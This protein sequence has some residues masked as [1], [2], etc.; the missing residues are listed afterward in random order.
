[1]VEKLIEWFQTEP[2][3]M[4]ARV[5]VNVSGKSITAQRYLDRLSEILD[6][7][8][9]A[10]GRLMFEITESCRMHDLQSANR[11]VQE[12][13]R[14]GYPIC[15]DDFGAGAANF[16]YLSSLEVDIV[17]LDGWSLRNAQKAHKGRA[18]LKALVGLCRD[19]DVATVAEMVEDEAGLEFVRDC[20]VQYVQGYLFG[21]PNS[22]IATF[23]APQPG[24]FH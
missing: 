9:W 2:G 19:L 15:L 14:R 8:P 5:A 7:H 4:D 10:R 11:C 6:R 21:R 12:L 3:A 16:H 20:G 23:R 24:H 1:M 17:K 18:F 13:R 22:D